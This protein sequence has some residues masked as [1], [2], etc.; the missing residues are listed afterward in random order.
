MLS[1]SL[2]LVPLPYLSVCVHEFDDQTGSVTGLATAH[3]LHAMSTNESESCSDH[4]PAKARRI[5]IAVS[6]S[7]S[8]DTEERCQRKRKRGG[9]EEEERRENSVH[10]KSL[11]V[12]DLKII[13]D[14]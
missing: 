4:H 13:R 5:K 9:G 1:C 12:G 7:E 6:Q 11:D 3:Q 14:A 10:L 2:T 8:Y